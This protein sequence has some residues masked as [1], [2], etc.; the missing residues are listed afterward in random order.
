MPLAGPCKTTPYPKTTLELDT[1]D[2][3]EYSTTLNQYILARQ[4]DLAPLPSRP[5]PMHTRDDNNEQTQ[6]KHVNWDAV[7]AQWRA[8]GESNCIICNRSIF[9]RPNLLLSCSH[10]VHETCC[11]EFRGSCGPGLVCPLCKC[12]ADGLFCINRQIGVCRVVLVLLC[13]LRGRQSSS[14][15]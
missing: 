11:K 13:R 5:Q 9:S 6:H 15:R 4:L 10:R 14:I 8:P 7:E 12:F 3:P 1:L 2:T